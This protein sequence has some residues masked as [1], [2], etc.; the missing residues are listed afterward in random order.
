MIGG[1]G[2]G[3]FLSGGHAGDYSDIIYKFTGGLHCRVGK[4][5]QGEAYNYQLPHTWEILA[6][7]PGEHTEIRKV[8]LKENE[9]FFLK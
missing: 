3:S 9:D 2:G 6:A 5:G 7:T 8:V 1:G 4:G